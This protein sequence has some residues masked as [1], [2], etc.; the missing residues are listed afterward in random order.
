MKKV[1]LGKTCEEIP[2]FRGKLVRKYR[3]LGEL[4]RKYRVLGELA[5]KYRVLGENL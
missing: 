5:R 3:V 1:F 2:G 4:V